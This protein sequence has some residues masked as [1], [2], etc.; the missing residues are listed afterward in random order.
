M[1]DF[2]KRMPSN[3][4]CGNFFSFLINGTSGW[5]RSSPGISLNVS[6]GQSPPADKVA[7]G[8]SDEWDE[9]GEGG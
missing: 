6:V 9:E 2:S 3:V 8:Y 4:R 1:E 7:L 5:K